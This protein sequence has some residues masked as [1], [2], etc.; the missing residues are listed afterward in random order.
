MPSKNHRKKKLK[1]TL[2]FAYG[3][4]LSMAGMAGRCPGSLPVGTAMLQDW[5]LTFRGVADVEPS[6]GDIVFG[7]LWTCPPR[8]VASLDSYEGVAGGFYR[9]EWLTVQAEAGPVKALVYVMNP[10]D[11]D[12]RS[13][14]S[15][16]YFNTI[17][18]GYEDFG[19]PIDSLD[20]ALRVTYDRV[21]N[22][23]GI[24]EFVAHGPK[25]M[26]PVGTVRRTAAEKR[27][28]KVQRK[29]VR[30]DVALTAQAR[31]E[32]TGRPRRQYAATTRSGI[33]V[34]LDRAGMSPATRAMYEAELRE[35]ANDKARQRGRRKNEAAL[36][37]LNSDFA[38]ANAASL[39]EEVAS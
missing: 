11:L 33:P 14:P 15:P 8:D 22:V 10:E 6:D 26:G 36:A 20:E 24:R 4:N 2:Y 27:A 37:V 21:V 5:R 35:R 1:S 9:R 3:S 17:V 39:G 38:A 28:L 12:N 30:K 18:N 32:P 23:K 7:A 31:P 19:L 25:R 34:N 13:L 29:R 16:G